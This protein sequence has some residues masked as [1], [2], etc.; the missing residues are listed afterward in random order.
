MRK[1]RNNSFIKE[2]APVSYDIGVFLSVLKIEPEKI[3]AT[4]FWGVLI[5]CRAEQVFLILKTAPPADVKRSRLRGYKLQNLGVSYPAQGEKGH[6]KWLKN[7]T[8]D[9]LRRNLLKKKRAVPN[10]DRKSRC[11]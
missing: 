2:K 6:L 3:Q 7:T 11:F 5:R 1:K 9:G 8:V 4:R 10:K